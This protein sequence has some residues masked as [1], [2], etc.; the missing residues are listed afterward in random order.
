MSKE[1]FDRKL[2]EIEALRSASEDTAG[3]QLRKALKDR[4]T[5]VAAKAASIAA[6]RQLRAL[7]PDLLIAF[8]RFMRE[9]IKSDPQCWAKNAIIK[10]L[11]DI[12]HSDAAIYL[13]GIEHFQMEPVW[14]GSEDTATTLRA[15]CAH[16]LV[17][18]RL[19]SLTI[20]IQLTNLL[21]DPAVPVRIDAARA[22]A[23]LSAPEGLLPLRLK[24]SVGDQEPEV[25]GHC[26]A[27]L[28]NL[29]PR[30]HLPFV[31]S[32]LAK[33]DP[34]IR[35]EA[36]AALAESR[37][38]QS[39]EILKE[40]WDRQAD[41]RIKH[42]LLTLLATSPL[43]ASVTFLQSVAESASPQIAGYARE[44]LSQSRHHR[45]EGFGKEC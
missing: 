11:K 29:D 31:A 34:D 33:E 25:T 3:P 8:D 14:G 7:E 27:S 32:F 21:T 1:S 18:C 12:G 10:A 20:L 37:E 26:L 9:P 23:Q 44:A 2:A 35:I 13:R 22:I 6:D 24:A 42:T 38:P 45:S 28:L 4:S 5:Y 39:L 40:F 17:S 30:G 19:D 43:P 36:A 15:T 16:A 41:P